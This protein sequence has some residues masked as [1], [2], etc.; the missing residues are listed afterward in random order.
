MLPRRSLAALPSWQCSKEC[1]SGVSV[2]L[3][4]DFERDFC[5]QEVGGE[6]YTEDTAPAAAFYRQAHLLTGLSS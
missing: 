2:G 4:T 6:I 1:G 5:E 3:V